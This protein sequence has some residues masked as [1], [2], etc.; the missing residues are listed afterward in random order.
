MFTLVLLAPILGLLGP[1]L[2][3]DS[4][5]QPAPCRFPSP[6]GYLPAAFQRA[7]GQTADAAAGPELLRATGP[8]SGLKCWPCTFLSYSPHL[9]G[10]G[11]PGPLRLTEQNTTDRAA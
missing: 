9:C 3:P 11:L 6:A 7:C 1:G 4:E 5:A 2:C 8:S 10:F